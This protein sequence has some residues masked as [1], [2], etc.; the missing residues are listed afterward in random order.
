M[1]YHNRRSQALTACHLPRQPLLA[2]LTK[3]WVCRAPSEVHAVRGPRWSSLSRPLRPVGRACRDQVEGQTHAGRPGRP[4]TITHSAPFGHRF[5]LKHPGF[6]ALPAVWS[7][8]VWSSRCLALY[9]ASALAGGLDGRGGAS[10]GRVIIV[11]TDDCAPILA[12]T[13]VNFVRTDDCA[14]RWPPEVLYPPSAF[15]S[16][17]EWPRGRHRRQRVPELV[18]HQPSRQALPRRKSSPRISG[19]CAT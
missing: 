1:A 3:L 7:R 4:V 6:D 19:T 15:A 11:R 16:Q 13:R 9:S 8:P 2:L 18:G 10:P 12:E 14:P 17:G 5:T